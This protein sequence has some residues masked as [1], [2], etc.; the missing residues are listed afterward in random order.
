MLLIIYL[1]N[2]NT[3]PC[4]MIAET[5]MRIESTSDF[6]DPKSFEKVFTDFVTL[7]RTAMPLKQKE[8]VD[9]FIGFWGDQT[10]ISIPLEFFQLIAETGWPVLFD[11]ND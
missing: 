6:D 2:L 7:A 8:N 10:T 1:R 4:E 3:S 9:V 11:I 5:E